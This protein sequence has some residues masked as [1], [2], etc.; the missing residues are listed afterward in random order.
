MSLDVGDL[1][2]ARITDLVDKQVTRYHAVAARLA[3]NCVQVKTWCVT[4]VGAIAALAVNNDEP[5]L[6]GVGLAI[7]AIFM[8]LDVQYLW[9]ERRFR[10]GAHQLVQRA[11]K[12]EIE[13][14]SELFATR[15]PPR[16]ER[17]GVLSVVKSFTILPFYVF[18]AALLIVGAVAT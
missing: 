12:G 9:L 2:D 7:V 6:F 4:A 17:G 10:E 15:A 5:A 16:G 18:V 11:S 14:L 13:A 8:A 3:S 1:P